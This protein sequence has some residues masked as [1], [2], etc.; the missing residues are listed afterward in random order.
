MN[1]A[2]TMKNAFI[3]SVPNQGLVCC[4]FNKIVRMLKDGDRKKKKE[5]VGWLA[6]LVCGCRQSTMQMMVMMDDDG[7]QK[8]IDDVIYFLVDIKFKF[9][10]D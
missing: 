5:Q 10:L 1:A 4:A 6:E 8:V 7:H 9:R 3:P 2:R